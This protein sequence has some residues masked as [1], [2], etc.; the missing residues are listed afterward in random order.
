MEA[1]LYLSEAQQASTILKNIR[2]EVTSAV[3]NALLRQAYD[4]DVM[5]SYQLCKVSSRSPVKHG[6]LEH[7]TS[8]KIIAP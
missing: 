2:D 5:R 4:T 3:R 1:I 7:F 6:N 8:H